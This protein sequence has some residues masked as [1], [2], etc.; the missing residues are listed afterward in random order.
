M[1][2]PESR[3]AKLDKLEQY[4]LHHLVEDPQDGTVFDSDILDMIKALKEKYKD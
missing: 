3:K 4:Y 2:N 1:K